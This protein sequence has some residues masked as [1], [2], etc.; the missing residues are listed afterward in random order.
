M[1]QKKYE[2]EKPLK[3]A[4]GCTLLVWSGM[5]FGMFETMKWFLRLDESSFLIPIISIFLML[6]GMIII[7]HRESQLKENGNIR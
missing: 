7:L 5:G 2:T 4:V 3:L 6:S 1:S